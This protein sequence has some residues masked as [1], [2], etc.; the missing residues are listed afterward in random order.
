MVAPNGPVTVTPTG[1]DVSSVTSHRRHRRERD[2]TGEFM[3]AVG[4][5]AEHFER[6]VDL[7][8]REFA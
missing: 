3:I 1:F 5:L 8:G 6:Q 2:E 4:A 7:G